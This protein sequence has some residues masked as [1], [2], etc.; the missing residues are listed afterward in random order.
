MLR[1]LF[2]IALVAIGYALYQKMRDKPSSAAAPP[3]NKALSMKRCTE[4]GMHLP[5]NECLTYHQQFFCSEEHK[6][7]YIETHPDNHD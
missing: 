6:Q 7:H 4:C 1:L 3:A 2:L 5:E